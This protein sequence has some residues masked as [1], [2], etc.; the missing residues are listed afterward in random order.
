MKMSRRIALWSFG[1]GL[2]FGVLLTAALVCL[3]FFCV[4]CT[5][6]QPMP[7]RRVNYT[8]K[9]RYDATLYQYL[10]ALAL[11]GA[12]LVSDDGGRWE[13]TRWGEAIYRRRFWYS[14]GRQRQLVEFSN[15]TWRRFDPIPK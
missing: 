7:P 14:D 11:P 8:S 2:S 12:T 15:G 4:S 5:T 3:A 1:T 10:D 13:T 9:A 6:A